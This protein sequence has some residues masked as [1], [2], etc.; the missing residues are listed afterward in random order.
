[1]RR[2]FPISLALALAV[3]VPA[4]AE[5]NL[6]AQAAGTLDELGTSMKEKGAVAFRERRFGDALDAF[7]LSYA[8][9]ANPA[10]LYNIGMTL[11]SL[12]RW[13]DALAYF[14]RF[15]K[16]A[17]SEL[18]AKVP[19]LDGLLAE[20][21][22]HIG[23]L[24]VTVNVKGATVIVN[25]RIVG[26]TP[27]EKPIQVKAGPNKIDV[28]AENHAGYKRMLNIQGGSTA[29]LDITLLLKSRAALL[30]VKSN[31]AGSE[32]FIDGKSAG[33][34]PLE[35][36]VEVGSHR[37]RIEKRGLK[38]VETTTVV[39]VGDRKEVTLNPLDDRPI[40]ERWYFWAGVGV[41]AAATVVTIH[42]LTTERDGDSGGLGQTTA[43]LIS[44]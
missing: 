17:P 15:K 11:R 26:Q 7:Q 28:V 20:V 5:Q 31:V 22:S 36:Q 10:L 43:P 35:V 3:S 18:R 33:T 8:A 9:K 21:E 37:L 32:V 42:A 24:D 34:P 29:T 41:V 16:D 4:Q 1:M 2:A 27:F 6:G 12:D 13:P 23:N 40:Y 30:V 39:A 38:R 25:D 44:F 14:K 19:D